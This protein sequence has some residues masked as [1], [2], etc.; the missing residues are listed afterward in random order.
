MKDPYGVV[1]KLAYD[2]SL[3]H[4]YDTLGFEVERIL[5]GGVVRSF[6]YDDIGRLV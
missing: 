2:L 1:T 4:I 5:P 6:A 3:I